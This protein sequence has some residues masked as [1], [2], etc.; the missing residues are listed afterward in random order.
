MSTLGEF[1]ANRIEDG[2]RVKQ[3]DKVARA[4]YDYMQPQAAQD[5]SQAANPL[6]PK[7]QWDTLSSQDRIARTQAFVQSQTIKQALDR[8]SQDTRL[9]ELK[10]SDLKRQFDAEDA[11]QRVLKDAGTM[12]PMEA[13]ALGSGPIN[14]PAVQPTPDRFIRGF[15]QNPMAINSRAGAPVLERILAAQAQQKDA[16]FRPGDTNFALPGVP[17]VLRIPLGPNSSQLVDAGNGQAIAIVGPNGENLGFGLP[18]RTTQPLKSGAITP[19]DQFDRM[20][21]LHREYIRQA[22]ESAK[23]GQKDAAAA[24][25]AQ[26][27]ALAKEMNGLFAPGGAAT[28]PSAQATDRVRVQD[29]SGKKF[30]VPRSQLDQAKREGYSEVK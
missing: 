25:Q 4:L 11:M 28:A 23:F 9:G 3:A 17:N 7:D 2:Q 6:G 30:T 15:T 12:M 21:Q 20:S 18:G 29:K 24:W 27:D 19:Q 1:L 10:I 14:P 16:F 8:A 13:L 26:A 22:G 5:G